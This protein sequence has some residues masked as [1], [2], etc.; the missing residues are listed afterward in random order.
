MLLKLSTKSLFSA[1]VGYHKSRYGVFR[2][3]KWNKKK[4]VEENTCGEFSVDELLSLT[5]Y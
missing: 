5:E 1:D 3:P 4:S 2:S